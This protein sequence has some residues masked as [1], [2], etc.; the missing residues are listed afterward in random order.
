MG[1]RAFLSARLRL[2]SVAHASA[3][4]RTVDALDVQRPPHRRERH[5]SYPR[6]LQRE[7][8]ETLRAAAPHVGA[9]RLP[10][11]CCGYDRTRRAPPAGGRLWRLYA[12]G[13]CDESQLAVV[14]QTGRVARAPLRGDGRPA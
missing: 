14:L 10:G 11:R 5:A 3:D 2:T 4:H 7:R 8:A 1:H 13:W 6:R 9:R 12:G